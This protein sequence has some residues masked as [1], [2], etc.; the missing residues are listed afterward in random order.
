LFKAYF[1]ST[2]ACNYGHGINPLPDKYNYEAA[3]AVRSVDESL[4]RL[5][6]DY[7]DLL[8]VGVIDL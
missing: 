7:V 4:E 5:K 2:K 3:A 6:L 1:I 8:Y